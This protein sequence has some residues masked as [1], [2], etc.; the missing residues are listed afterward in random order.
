MASDTDEITIVRKA[1]IFVIGKMGA[2]QDLALLKSLEKQC[3]QP[4]EA[5]SSALKRIE[6]RSK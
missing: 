5:A 4:L 3:L 1:T 6:A 2:K